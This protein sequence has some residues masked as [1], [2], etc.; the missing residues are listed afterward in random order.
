[1]PGDERPQLDEQPRF[2]VSR[3]QGDVIRIELSGGDTSEEHDREFVNLIR[4]KAHCSYTI[5]I[6]HAER[7]VVRIFKSH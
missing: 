7:N 6:T 4:E 1:M 5:V 2:R 3:G